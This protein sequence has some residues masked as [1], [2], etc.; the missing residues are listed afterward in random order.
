MYTA[1]Y[2]KLRPVNFSDIVGQKHVVRTLTN[3]IIHNRISH[4]YLFCGT[5]GTGKTSTAK[6]FAKAINCHNPSEGEAC[7]AC[8]SCKA[9]AAKTQLDIIEM[10]AASNNGVDNIRDLRDEIKYPPSEKYK[11]YIIDE[12]HMLS[13]GAFNALLKT[14]EEPPAHCIFILATTDPHK[15]PATIHSRVMRFDFY[16]ISLEIMADVLSKY[17]QQ[18]NIDITA[19][20]VKY[21]A[22]LADGSMRDALSILDRV[23]GLYFNEK[24]GLDNVLELTGS[25][26]DSV[27]F[28]LCEAL[29]NKNIQSCLDIIQNIVEL[30]R[31]IHQFNDEFVHFLRDMLVSLHDNYMSEYAES[32][33]SMG[34]EV[35]VNLI[36]SFAA[37]SHKLRGVGANAR[38]LFEIKCVEYIFGNVINVHEPINVVA[39]K[40]M[41]STKV[42][43][44]SIQKIAPKKAIPEDMRDV[45]K[46]WRDI[47]QKFA[48]NDASFLNNTLAGFLD[49]QY[50]YIVCTDGF[51]E[52]LLRRKS[53]IIED[54]LKKIYDKEFSINIVSK[55]IYDQK[56]KR[57]YGI[58]DSF[59]YAEV[60]FKNMQNMVNF[61]ID[62]V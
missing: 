28:S 57:K 46:N 40:N 56:H 29:N 58:V 19:D 25:V 33:N 42:K 53:D 18:E 13:T 27:H 15:I 16:R 45:L 17:M 5:R 41:Q 32:A 2:R 4:A 62:S 30:G 3:Q 20:A 35:I 38:I 37:L 8:G 12:V 61:P 44:E 60:A 50:L 54:M 7:G 31:D 11:I 49:D 6:V 1:L 26:D 21:I 24:I 51:T 23:S 39:Q 52:S 22:K 47:C 55:V 9:I 34:Y 36:A 43:E 14:L 48:E 59:D 10:D